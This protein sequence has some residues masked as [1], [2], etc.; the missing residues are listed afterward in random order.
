MAKQHQFV[1]SALI[2]AAQGSMVMTIAATQ[3]A[4]TIAVYVARTR[5]LD[6]PLTELALLCIFSWWNLFINHILVFSYAGQRLHQAG[7]S[8]ELF[9]ILAML[10]FCAYNLE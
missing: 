8:G 2:S 9:P 4:I 10:F 7:T 6:N 3:N 5:L 1:Y